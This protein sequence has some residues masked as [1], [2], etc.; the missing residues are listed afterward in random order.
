MPEVTD[1]TPDQ[2]R[3]PELP[4]H[5]TMPL[6]ELLTKQAMD[7]EYQQAA[8]RTQDD[9]GGAGSGSTPG[10]GQVLVLVS[11]LALLGV[12]TATAFAQTER[13]SEINASSREVLIAEIATSRLAVDRLRER[14]SRLQTR[15]LTIQSEIAAEAE[16]LESITART[17]RLAL[18]SGYASAGGPGLRITIQ[19]PIDASD[20]TEVRDEDL[21]ILVDGLWNAGA[22][23]ISIN[24]KRLT[25]L[26]PIRN[27][28]RAIRVNSQSISPPYVVSAIGDPRDLSAR[29]LENT[30]G[31]EWFALVERFGFRT[32]IDTVD[33]LVL[34]AAT[35]RT[36]R[37]VRV[38]KPAGAGVDLTDK[39]SEAP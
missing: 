14:Q 36:L 3:P 26:S 6:L 11:V 22:E 5:V 13:N 2:T 8:R 9:G 18:I 32:E 37:Y 16:Q 31:L 23:A 19:N 7:D 25:V 15:I 10:P 17:Q 20:T 35:P 34:P 29:L 27:S 24:G 30:H 38:A 4:P 39:D 28:G 1:S 33:A 21:A 12:L